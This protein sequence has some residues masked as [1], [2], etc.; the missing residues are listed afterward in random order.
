[1]LRAGDRAPD[2]ELPDDSGRKVRLTDLLRD[3]PLILY[4]YPADFTPVCTREACMFRDA[5]QDLAA[6]N[7]RVV[8]V[9]AGAAG[10]HA[11][12]RERCRLPFSLLSDPGKRVAR[13]YGARG[14]LGLW[15]KR[16]SYLIGPDGEVLDA[17]RGD[18]SLGGHREF[19]ARALARLGTAAGPMDQRPQEGERR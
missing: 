16:I 9:S 15:V 17:A 6:R 3:G 7:V 18:Y 1:M 2:F 14:P 5:H 19:V 10:T 4:F 8:G 13:A 11:R 12:F